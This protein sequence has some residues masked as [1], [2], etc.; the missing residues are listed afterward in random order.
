MII[1]D[2]IKKELIDY[3]D[4]MSINYNGY[5]KSYSKE[6]NKIREKY[7]YKDIEYYQ[8]KSDIDKI[9]QIKRQLAFMKELWES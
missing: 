2:Q 7:I 6:L 5:I 9:N 8:C 1:K 3:I 4:D